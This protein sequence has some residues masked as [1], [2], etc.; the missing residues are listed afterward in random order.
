MEGSLHPMLQ[1]IL[2]LLSQLHSRADSDTPAAPTSTS[3]PDAA[4]AFIPVLLKASC[5]RH[6][7]ARSMSARA[8]VSLVSS[9]KRPGVLCT[10]LASVPAETSHSVQFNAV[11]GALLQALHLFQ[12]CQGDD[13]SVINFSAE[14]EKVCSLILARGW[15][16]TPQSCPCPPV[17]HVLLE[18]LDVLTTLNV[19]L[20]ADLQRMRSS[21]WSSNSIMSERSVS[22]YPGQPRLSQDAVAAVSSEITSLNVPQLLRNI[23]SQSA[24]IRRGALL[25]AI[26]G[27]EAMCESKGAAALA[28]FAR[29]NLQSLALEVSRTVRWE[30]RFSPLFQLTLR[31]LC[32]VCELLLPSD[33]GPGSS[34]AASLSELQLVLTEYAM[35]SMNGRGRDPAHTFTC[36]DA[37]ELSGHCLRLDQR[38]HGEIPWSKVVVQ[39]SKPCYS[40][41]VR[42]AAASSILASGAMDTAKRSS[43]EAAYLWLALLRLV[44]DDDDR[45]RAVARRAAFM[46]QNRTEEQMT[47]YVEGLTISSIFSSLEAIHSLG[48][49]AEKARV[50]R[51]LLE[52]LHSSARGLSDAIAAVREEVHSTENTSAIFLMEDLNLH[53]DKVLISQHAARSL[54]RLG[55]PVLPVE[56]PETHCVE[57]PE[58]L[59]M[60]LDLLIW[61]ES[62]LHKM[63]EEDFAEMWPGGPSYQPDLFCGIHS[64][65]LAAMAIKGSLTHTGP[66]TTSYAQLRCKL[67]CISASVQMIVESHQSLKVHPALSSSLYRLCL[68]EITAEEE[69][70]AV[71]LS[72]DGTFFL[73]HFAGFES[74]ASSL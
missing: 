73:T 41:L 12:A 24:D 48:S 13:D 72:S 43:S 3:R 46:C 56:A 31:L 47:G 61:M 63:F 15:L 54:L 6:W 4:A 10:I 23:V 49:A 44:Q 21:C 71:S 33:V 30:D 16:G 68:P 2:L 8:L 45:V 19:P 20:L 39:A 26:S 37:V 69:T 28:A 55:L 50:I 22:L 5:A 64:T 65:F 53:S 51:E 9:D 57:D 11:H 58:C 52:I 25:G 38:P 36:A 67:S 17:R 7:M 74:L 35:S 60:S 42:R 29:G 14:Y 66:G 62:L 18:I 27:L 59:Q 1:P 40:P 34:L 32:R 70:L